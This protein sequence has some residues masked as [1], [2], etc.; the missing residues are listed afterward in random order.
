MRKLL[1]FWLLGCLLCGCSTNATNGDD[2]A[3]ES[4]LKKSYADGYNDGYEACLNRSQE[5]IFE[6]GHHE[7][8]LLIANLM[9]DYQYDTVEEI[10]NY[11]PE[12]VEEAL[13]C[14]FGTRDMMSVIEYL[15]D[16]RIVQENTVVGI[17]KYCNETVYASDAVHDSSNCTSDDIHQSPADCPTHSYVHSKCLFEN[18]PPKINK[19]P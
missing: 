6:E 8:R 1:T 4:A 12:D 17:C 5:D 16:N 10:Y 13:E 19:E 3:M 9:Y 2:L 7:F 14:E 18:D 15:E 11:Y